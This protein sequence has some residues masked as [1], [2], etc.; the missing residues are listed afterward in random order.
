MRH[1]AGVTQDQGYQPIGTSRRHWLWQRPDH[2]WQ[3]AVIAIIAAATFAGV[4]YLVGRDAVSAAVGA[5][6]FGLAYGLLGAYRLHRQR[7]E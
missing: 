5:G 4:G 3:V 6:A 7:G 1:P 2:G